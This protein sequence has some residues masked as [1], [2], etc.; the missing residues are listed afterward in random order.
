MYTTTSTTARATPVLEN[1]QYPPPTCNHG[2]VDFRCSLSDEE[3]FA[4]VPKAPALIYMVETEEVVR[5][6]GYVGQYITYDRRLGTGSRSGTT[7]T[8]L[9][10]SRY[11]G[12]EYMTRG[13][14]ANLIFSNCF[15]LMPV[16]LES[17]SFVSLKI[18][19]F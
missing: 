6:A 12:F 10:S 7:G 18:S 15:P 13:T 9:P 16:R 11:R 4:P 1:R 8:C 3:R 17:R 5:V 2:A 19:P 14:T